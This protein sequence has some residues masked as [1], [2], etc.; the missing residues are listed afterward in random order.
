M[1]YVVIWGTN[2]TLTREVMRSVAGAK[3]H[4][5]MIFAGCNMELSD[6]VFTA[7]QDWDPTY[8]RYIF[9]QDFYDF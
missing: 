8:L 4:F 5:S 7:N 2:L 9:S 6:R 1:S 3:D